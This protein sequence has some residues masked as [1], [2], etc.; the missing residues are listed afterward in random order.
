VRSLPLTADR[1]S[2][3][4]AFYRALVF[5][6][7]AGCTDAHAKNYSLMLEQRSVRLAPLYDLLSYA[8]YWDGTVRIDSAMSIGGEYR[9]GGISSTK[10]EQAGALF[11]LDSAEAAEIVDATRKGVY[12]AFE[13][14]RATVEVHGGSALTVGDELLRGL[15]KLPLVVT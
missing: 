8:A 7:I 4:E 9:L 14:A 6:V 5:N 15:R 11:G 3:G 1:R 13:S 10:L 2:T 12:P